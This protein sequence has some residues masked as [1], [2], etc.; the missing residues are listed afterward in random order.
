MSTR[1]P[2]SWLVLLLVV[3]VFAFFAYHIVQ[4]S[5]P[6][7]RNVNKHMPPTLTVQQSNGEAVDYTMPPS[8]RQQEQ[9]QQQ[10]PVP[11]Y[12]KNPPKSDEADDSQSYGDA[13]QSAEPAS[14]PMPRVVGQT[15]EDLRAPEPLQAT[16]PTTQYDP[17]E[18]TDPMNRH[19]HMGAEFGSNLRHPEQMIERRPAA[20]MASVVPSGLGSDVSR[21]GNNRQVSFA[22]EMAQNGGEFME[23]IAAF[24]GSEG[25]VGYA[26]L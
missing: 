9:P 24:D 8:Q 2:L 20:T 14:R 3:G 7:E 22:P 4:A 11:T 12:L 19:V 25:G 5:V 18:A 13:V 15:D 6:E 1:I 23:G 26:M 21:T 10:R 16:P 17:P